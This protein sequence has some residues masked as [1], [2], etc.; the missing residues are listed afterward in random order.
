MVFQAKG[1]GELVNR[2]A[3]KV[4]SQSSDEGNG[5]R[6]GNGGIEKW[7]GMGGRQQ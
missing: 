6:G 3:G 5:G 1:K 4:G 2:K 7:L